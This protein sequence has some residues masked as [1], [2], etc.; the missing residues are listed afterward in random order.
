ML[1]DDRS[2]DVRIVLL[3]EAAKIL[4]ASY[5][6]ALRV[7]TEGDLKAFRIRHTWR[8]S[9]AACEEFVQRKFDEQARAC[10]SIQAD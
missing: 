2:E 9:T 3:K 1:N 7:A 10:Q 5:P 6:T 4:G 8:T